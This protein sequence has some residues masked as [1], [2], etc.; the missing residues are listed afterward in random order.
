MRDLAE[1]VWEGLRA[2][3]LYLAGIWLA[4]ALILFVG[5]AMGAEPPSGA[6]DD[7]YL[8]IVDRPETDWDGAASLVDER[9]DLYAQHVPG[10][11]RASDNGSPLPDVVPQ[12]APGQEVD[13]AVDTFRALRSMANERLWGPFVSVVIM[14]LLSLLS[15]LILRSRE[16][17]DKVKPYM[18]EI[19]LAASVLGYVAMGLA[20]LP[21]GA[22]VAAWWGVIGPG[23]KTGLAAVGGYELLIKRLLQHWLPKLLGLFRKQKE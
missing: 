6:T 9:R 8:V 11:I 16:F 13:W 21:A 22:D 17:R 19:A 10:E 14:A 2:S 18:G 20:T 23:I 7:S 3:I 5:R 15:M 1:S 12:V 4:V